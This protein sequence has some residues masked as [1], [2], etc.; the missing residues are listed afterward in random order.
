[1]VNN[2]KVIDDS[3]VDR[4]IIK[5]I[6]DREKD[7]IGQSLSSFLTNE[8]MDGKVY[9]DAHTLLEINSDVGWRMNESYDDVVCECKE[10]YGASS[11]TVLDIMTEFGTNMKAKLLYEQLEDVEASRAIIEIIDRAMV[12]LKTYPNKGEKFYNILLNTYLAKEKLTEK[13]LKL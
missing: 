8:K 10:I 3:L 6:I 11:L 5:R 7:D 12:R 2:K 4:E 13:E 9:H 1:M